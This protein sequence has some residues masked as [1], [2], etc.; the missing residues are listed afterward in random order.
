MK[1]SPNAGMPGNGQVPPMPPTPPRPPMPPRK[2]KNLTWL[3][4]VLVIF[5]GLPILAVII[6][7]DSLKDNKE[8]NELKKPSKESWTETLMSDL[9]MQSEY[10]DSVIPRAKATTSPEMLRSYMSDMKKIADKVITDSTY[11]EVYSTPEVTKLMEEN[12]KKAKKVLPELGTICRKQYV[13]QLGDKL[14][15]EN[16]YVESSN[17]AKTITFIGAVFASNKNI[18]AWQDELGDALKEMGFTRVEYKWIK[19]DPEYTYYD[20]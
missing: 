19:H 8:K 14:W 2:K 18:K 15:E 13:K 5:V 4:I 9:A 17:N 6:S 3:W 12:S 20:L 7:P 10:I 1:Q 16:I 11:M